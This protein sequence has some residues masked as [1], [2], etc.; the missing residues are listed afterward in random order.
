MI[1]PHLL[2]LAGSFAAI[3]FQVPVDSVALSF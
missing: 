2:S 3:L 1:H